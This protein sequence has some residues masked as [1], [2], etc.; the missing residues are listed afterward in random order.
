MSVCVDDY[1]PCKHHEPCFARA[2]GNELWVLILEKA[3]AKIHGSYERVEGGQAHLTL[4]DLTGAPS[5]EY[6]IDKTEDM[7]EKIVT[8]DRSEWAMAAG[9]QSDK[10]GG[11][12]Q[13]SSL[14]LVGE[15]S[16]GIIAAQEIE[17]ADGN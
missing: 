6:I 17:D 8:A 14:G 12:D 10:A 3:W 1:I 7:Y 15:H 5:Y 13:I 16:Y 11:K 9:C 2:H 4:R